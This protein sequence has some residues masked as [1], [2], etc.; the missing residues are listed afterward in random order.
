MTA[1]Q[2]EHAQGAKEQQLYQPQLFQ[3]PAASDPEDRRKQG[4]DHKHRR[5]DD[6]K[7]KRAFRR[8]R[9]SDQGGTKINERHDAEGKYA[10]GD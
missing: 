10:G 5:P 2:K 4:G 6:F 1:S 3:R 8:I 7:R 9:P